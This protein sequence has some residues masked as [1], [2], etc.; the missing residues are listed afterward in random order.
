M[1]KIPHCGS[2]VNKKTC[3]EV[4]N[5]ILKNTLR[6][7]ATFIPAGARANFL[8]KRQKQISALNGALASSNRFVGQE[9]MENDRSGFKTS[10]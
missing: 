4:L 7:S 10:D 2:C 8:P 5:V 9:I 6:R 1:Q 3:R